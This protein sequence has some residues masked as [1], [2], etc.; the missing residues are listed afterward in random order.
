MGGNIRKIWYVSDTLPSTRPPTRPPAPGSG[1]LSGSR[2]RALP[3]SRA[4][5]VAAVTALLV[6]ALGCRSG[7]PAPA[8]ID[9]SRVGIALGPERAVATSTTLPM[10]G[11]RC[12]GNACTCRERGANEA[13][14]TPP[15]EGMKR[16]EER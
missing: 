7:Q 12:V 8:P 9:P 13:E 14:T 10:A 5:A 2:L 4:F 11:S 15:A 16:P 1:C 6:G 3:L